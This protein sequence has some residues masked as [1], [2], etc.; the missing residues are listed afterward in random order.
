MALFLEYV[1]GW[2]LAATICLIVGIVLMVVEMFTP[3]FGLAG[4]LGIVALLAA[5]VLRAD[6]FVTGM[7]TLALILLIL[8]L[9]G[10]FF[11]RSFSKGKLSRSSIVLQD[12]IEGESTSLGREASQALIGRE[13]TC[14]NV[15]R[16]AGNADFDGQKMDVVSAGEFLPAGTRVRIVRIEGARILVEP[17][18]EQAAAKEEKQDETL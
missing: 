10:V 17:V 3:G 12:A 9:F 7:I 6:N 8:L 5:V 14:V 16:P 18:R 13:G 4:G 15:L 2:N 11:F 1:L